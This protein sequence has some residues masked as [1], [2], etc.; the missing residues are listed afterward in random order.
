MPAPR[1]PS[2]PAAHD[3]SRARVAGPS[4]A[5]RA[6][7]GLRAGCRWVLGDRAEP[8][9]P[10]TPF[11]FL[12]SSG[13]PSVLAAALVAGTLELV[14]GYVLVHHLWGPAASLAHTAVAA[15]GI[16]WM[17]ADWRALRT[18]PTV[19]SGRALHVRAGLRWSVDVP[20]SAIETIYHVRRALPSDRPTVV[21]TPGAPAFAIDLR[22]P[23]RARGPYG[24]RRAVTRV[25][26]G[27]DDPQ[28][29]VQAMDLALNGR[30]RLS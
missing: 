17:A 20:L 18:R 6:L 26:I 12:E 19:L 8:T 13:Y 28:A 11:P 16:A 30:P 21:A 1:A 14:G 24:I 5:P 25:A 27:A 4:P 7:A 3:G 2:L 10:G 22:Q 23:V 29:F 9:P 15:Y